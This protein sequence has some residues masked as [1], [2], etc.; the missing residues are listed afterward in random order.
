MEFLLQLVTTSTVLLQQPRKALLGRCRWRKDAPSAFSRLKQTQF[1]HPFL[2]PHVLQH[3]DHLGDLL[4]LSLQFVSVFLLLGAQ[5]GHTSSKAV[6]FM[7]NGR[8]SYKEQDCHEL[9][10][11]QAVLS[12]PKTPSPQLASIKPP[13]T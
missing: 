1:S 9:K 7:L 4:L 8:V 11:Y 2:V 12:S 3:F 6:L 5:T 13:L 10:T